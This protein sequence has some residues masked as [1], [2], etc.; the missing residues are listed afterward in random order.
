ATPASVGQL[1]QAVDA[2]AKNY[3]SNANLAQDEAAWKA[4]GTAVEAFAKG[5]QGGP[6]SSTPAAGAVGA[7]AGAMPGM[8]IGLGMGMGD[9]GFRILVGGLLQGP[10]LT[11]DEVASL[12][13]AV[14]TFA[15]SYTSGADAAKDQAAVTALQS[16]L[17]SVAA[18][19][20]AKTVP[21]P[22]PLPLPV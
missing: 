6:T 20:W 1:Q 2:F 18:D 5:L 14:D 3:S 13:G 22:T 16:S 19:H 8:G 10:A 11:K 12:Q 7:G 17:S 9:P 15:A 4:L 21:T